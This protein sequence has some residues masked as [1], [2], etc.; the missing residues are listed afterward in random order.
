MLLIVRRWN[1]EYHNGQNDFS[2]SVFWL[3]KYEALPVLA[4]LLN[5]FHAIVRL[6]SLHDRLKG[7]SNNDEFFVGSMAGAA[8]R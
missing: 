2:A 1:V 8:R 4:R 5:T 6:N 3:T 7:T